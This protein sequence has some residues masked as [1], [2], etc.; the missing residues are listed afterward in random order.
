MKKSIAFVCDVPNW[1]FEIGAKAIKKQLEEEYNVDI[2]S[3]KNDVYKED[4]FKVLEDVKNYDHIHFFWRKTLLQLEEEKFLNDLKNI[5]MTFE[6][7]MRPIIPKLSTGIYDHAFLDKDSINTY[8]NI[9]NKY[10]SKYIVC[11][12]KLYN[13][14]CNIE[15]YKNPWGIIIDTY[16]ESIFQASNLDRFNK[17]D[18]ELVVGWVGN[19]AWQIETADFKGVNTILNPVMKELENEGYN[20]VKRYADKVT[21]IITNDKMP[22]YYNSIDICVCTSMYEGTPRPI[23]ESMA[24]GVPIISTDVGIVPEVFGEKQKRYIIGNRDDGTNDKYIREKLKEK[25]IDLYNNRYKLKEL[26]EE[27]LYMASKACSK[28]MQ[29]KYRELFK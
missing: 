20:I 24:C 1:A 8:K 14:Y 4:L 17:Y 18:R 10:V 13:I 19:S 7:Y 25:I 15:E 16:D 12:Q 9:L 21:G 28:N 27:N 2:F 29:I 23:I 6:E 11:S 26:S 3:S 22:N 5:G